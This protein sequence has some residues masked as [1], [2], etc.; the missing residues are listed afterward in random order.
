VGHPRRSRWIPWGE[1][2]LDKLIR[3]AEGMD[4]RIFPQS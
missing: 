3:E 1:G 2:R 4:V